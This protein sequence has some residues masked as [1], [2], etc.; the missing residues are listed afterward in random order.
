MTKLAALPLHQQFAS[1]LCSPL[2]SLRLSPCI[3]SLHYRHAHKAAVPRSCTGT[4]F[5]L[6]A[7]QQNSKA[8]TA[9]TPMR[10]MCNIVLL[11]CITYAGTASHCLHACSA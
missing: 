1:T 2:Q 9:P 3:S 10:I 11:A 7:L 6:A 4:A 5:Q 8:C